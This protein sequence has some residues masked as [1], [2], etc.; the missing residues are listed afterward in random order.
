MRIVF[1]TAGP[2]SVGNRLLGEISMVRQRVLW[3]MVALVLF[4]RAG[5][6]QTVAIAQITG[7][8]QR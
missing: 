2:E 6:A 1:A 8:V 7:V 5:H 3:L 4:G